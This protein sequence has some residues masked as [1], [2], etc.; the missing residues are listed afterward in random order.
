MRKYKHPGQNEEVKKEESKGEE[1][2]AEGATPGKAKYFC[3]ERRRI[4]VQPRR[5]LCLCG[6]LSKMSKS[7]PP[8]HLGLAVYAT[9]AQQEGNITFKQPGPASQ[10][11][12]LCTRPEEASGLCG[13]SAV[14][15]KSPAKS[16][17]LA[18]QSAT[19]CRKTEDIAI[20]GGKGRRV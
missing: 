13:A 11:E 14:R 3:K 4:D 1:V 6:V 17:E 9:H 20:E 2:K 18:V 15:I 12:S 16:A 19:V 5:S 8:A 10:F 7:C